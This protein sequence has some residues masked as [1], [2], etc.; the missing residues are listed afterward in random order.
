[1][2]Q[3]DINYGARTLT[4]YTG[5]NVRP[6]QTVK[7]AHGIVCLPFQ[8]HMSH[9]SEA[10]ERQLK[11]LRGTP[12]TPVSPA[13]SPQ[14]PTSDPLP[15]TVLYYNKGT[16]DKEYRVQMVKVEESLGG[17]WYAVDVQWGRRGKTLQRMRKSQ[18]LLSAAQALRLYHDIIKD[19]KAGGYQ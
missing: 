13:V 12:D 8:K 4:G 11:L 5:Q 16:S 6:K 2:G 17:P 19:K 9:L 7:P 3:C 10:L 15:S 14:A 18:H 1:M